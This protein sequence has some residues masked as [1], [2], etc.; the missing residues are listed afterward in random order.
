MAHST[1]CLTLAKHEIAG[2]K[3]SEEGE[4]AESHVDMARGRVKP[5]QAATVSKYLMIC[6]RNDWEGGWKEV[7]ECDARQR[8]AQTIRDI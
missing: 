5:G 3:G 1:D 8:V 7:A 6:R 4:L 2:E